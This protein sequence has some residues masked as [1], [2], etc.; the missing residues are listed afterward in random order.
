[1]GNHE[2]KHVEIGAAYLACTQS[3]G[4]AFATEPTYADFGSEHRAGS[5]SSRF[6]LGVWT[7]PTSQ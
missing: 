6:E 4:A 3:L 2:S 5:S 1:M 7:S